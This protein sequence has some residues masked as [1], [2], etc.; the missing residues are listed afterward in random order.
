MKAIIVSDIYGAHG[1]PQHYMAGWAS[2]LERRGYE[3]GKVHLNDLYPDAYLNSPFSKEL[4]HERFINGGIDEA[5]VQLLNVL[6]KRPVELLLGFSLGGYLACL[7][8][9]FLKST[10]KIICI[11]AT[12]LRHCEG[13]IGQSDVQAVFGED[14]PYRPMHALHLGG[15]CHEYLIPGASHEVYLDIDSCAF[16]L[17][18]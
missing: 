6:S 16:V 11:S 13:L 15:G 17:D 14:D 7:A 12:R 10:T 2:Q 8:R 5:V 9:P 3:V 4:T 18:K 1:R